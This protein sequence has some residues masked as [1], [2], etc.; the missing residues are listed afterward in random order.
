MRFRFWASQL[1]WI[2]AVGVAALAPSEGGSALAGAFFIPVIVG[3]FLSGLLMNWGA[4]RRQSS[5]A[6]NMGIA[7][8]VRAIATVTLWIT[9][10][11]L[12]AYA[13][14]VIGWVTV[15]LAFILFIPLLIS[16]YLLWRGQR[17]EEGAMRFNFDFNSDEDD[18][19]KRKRDRI[20]TVL[21]DLSDDDLIRLRERLADGTINDNVLYEKIVGD[22]GEL[23]DYQ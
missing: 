13:L 14:E 21:R 12:L 2:L 6:D 8:V 1:I 5:R 20:D 23:V 4:V 9:Y 3:F 10:L 15:P 11:G 16:N 7:I 18:R 17:G 19:E 22:D